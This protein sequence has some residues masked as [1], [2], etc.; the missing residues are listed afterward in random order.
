ME[1]SYEDPLDVRRVLIAFGYQSLLIGGLRRSWT[2]LLAR[3]PIKETI[4]GDGRVGIYYS[5]I[6]TAGLLR[7]RMGDARGG[8]GCCNL[9]PRPIHLSTKHGEDGYHDLVLAFSRPLS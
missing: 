2:A 5:A 8:D 9:H 4:S 3:A 7:M 6:P 1:S